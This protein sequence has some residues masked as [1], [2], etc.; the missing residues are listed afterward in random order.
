MRVMEIKFNISDDRVLRFKNRLC[1]PSDKE[2]KRLILDE[3]YKSLYIVHP[4]NTKMYRDLR[5]SFWWCGMKRGIVKFVEQ[6]LTC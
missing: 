2:I 5:E 4:S 3:A 6:C 1:A